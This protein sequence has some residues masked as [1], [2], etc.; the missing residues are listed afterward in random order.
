M[1]FHGCLFMLFA[2]ML[3][4]GTDTTRRTKPRSTKTE[5]RGTTPLHTALL[6][7]HSVEEVRVLLRAG[8]AN[9]NQAMMETGDTPLYIA[10]QQGHLDAVRALVDAGASVDQAVDD[11]ATPLCIAA[12]DGHL[13]VVR[14]LVG[15]GAS[16]EL[17]MNDGATP[18]FIAAQR[19]HLEVV[20]V[21]LKAGA[22]PIGQQVVGHHAAISI[23]GSTPLEL[24]LNEVRLD[25][26]RELQAAERWQVPRSIASMLIPSIALMII[27][28]FLWATFAFNRYVVEPILRRWAARTAAL[29]EAELLVADRSGRNAQAKGA[30]KQTQRPRKAGQPRRGRAP[31]SPPPPPP[32][33]AQNKKQRRD[34]RRAEQAEEVEAERVANMSFEEIMAKRAE[35]KNKAL[36]EAEAEAEAETKA[37]ARAEAEAGA[38]RASVAASTMSKDKGKGGK[39]GVKGEKDEDEDEERRMCGKC[40]TL[41]SPAEPPFKRCEQPITPSAQEN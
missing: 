39:K 6:Q 33:P 13:E 30:A 23:V 26:V 21:L 36:E 35:D 15:A 11:G 34:A 28:A 10:A 29:H 14:A 24:A 17:A 32:P 20:R 2:G 3:F 38:E 12:E 27:I 40:G 22:T 5:R 18:L 31:P 4:E 41:E 37:K 8:E 9:V 19:G 16:V 25:I 1:A 7:G